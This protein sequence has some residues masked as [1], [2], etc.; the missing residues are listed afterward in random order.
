MGGLA[1]IP[2]ERLI[3]VE[4]WAIKGEKGFIYMIKHKFIN[5]MNYIIII[6]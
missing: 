4:F 2:L 6:K 3:G 1:V 5:I